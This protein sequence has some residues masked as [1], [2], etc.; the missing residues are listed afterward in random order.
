MK[1]GLFITFE[2]GE[3]SGKTTAIQSVKERLEK[4]GHEVVIT[5]EPGG[6]TLAEEIRQLIL[7]QEMDAM[8]EVLLFAS[9]RMEH[10]KEVV[11]PAL[12]EGKIVLCDRFVH[13]SY[14]YQGIV[15]GVGLE[16]V[17]QI[18]ELVIGDY[19]PDATVHLDLDARMGLYRIQANNRETNKM[20]EYDLSFH[21]SV[22]EGY[23]SVFEKEDKSEVFWID[24]SKHI[25]DV[26][27]MASIQVLSFVESKAEAENYPL[28]LIEYEYPQL[29]AIYHAVGKFHTEEEA[30]K[31]FLEGNPDMSIR[32]ISRVDQ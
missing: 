7:F 21:E 11:I 12:D 6:V 8:T 22:R 3:G 29:R 27:V 5:R 15:K 18:N 4:N 31:R 23:R 14:V 2:G 25:E 20:D 24:A 16:K 13:S 9:A 19:Y 17:K 30:N 26:G 28:F 32:T 10:L 1:K